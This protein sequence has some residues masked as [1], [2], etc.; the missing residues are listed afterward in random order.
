[1]G[2]EDEEEDSLDMS[3]HST[4]IQE[5]EEDEE[6][7]DTSGLDLDR[8]MVDSKSEDEELSQDSDRRKSRLRNDKSQLEIFKQSLRNKD[9]N[10]LKAGQYHFSLPSHLEKHYRVL[11]EGRAAAV[12]RSMQHLWKGWI[13]VSVLISRYH[14]FAFGH[15][16]LKPVSGGYSDV[17]GGVG[18]TL[19]DSLDTLY[20]LGMKEE[21]DEAC[22]WVIDNLNLTA[23][24]NVSVFE[25]NIRLLGGLLSAY[26]L[27][28]REGLLEKAKEVG[29]LLKVAFTDEFT[30]PT[31]ISFILVNI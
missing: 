5:E 10:F 19:V 11:N 14:Q 17:W 31:V 23:D 27:S 30:L 16:E 22:S 2:E 15:D 29:E 13:L 21:F 12:K 18:M 3:Q 4:T 25:Y 24:Q 1:M 20:L 8:V 9:I 7:N 6:E 26:D 28:G